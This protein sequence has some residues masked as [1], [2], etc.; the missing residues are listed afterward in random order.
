MSEITR[1]PWGDTADELMREYH[2]KQWGKPGFDE[3]T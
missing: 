1:C 3:R 2:D